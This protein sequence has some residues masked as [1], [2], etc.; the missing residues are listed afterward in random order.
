MDQYCH[1]AGLPDRVPGP[2]FA[3]CDVVLLLSYRRLAGNRFSARLM[4]CQPRAG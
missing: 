4:Q 3:R 1:R 2:R